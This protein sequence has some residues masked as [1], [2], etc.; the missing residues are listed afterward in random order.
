MHWLV[1]I[2]STPL[3]KVLSD[4]SVSDVGKISVC[5]K[6]PGWWKGSS[7]MESEFSRESARGKT[8][9]SVMHEVIQSL[10][11]NIVK[12][13]FVQVPCPNG[14]F[15]FSMTLIISEVISTFNFHGSATPSLRGGDGDELYGPV[16]CVTKKAC[17]RDL[18]CLFLQEKAP[19][20]LPVTC[21]A[22][23]AATFVNDF[24]MVYQGKESVSNDTPSP[25]LEAC[26][27]TTTTT[28][29]FVTNN[30]RYR[31]NEDEEP[32]QET[33]SLETTTQQ[34]VIH[35]EHRHLMKGKNNHLVVK[36]S[37]WNLEEAHSSNAAVFLKSDFNEIYN[38][39]DSL[40]DELKNNRFY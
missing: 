37:N 26:G 6:S 12:G 34:R 32:L 5:Q 18:A 1:V 19:F 16:T 8:C 25:L 24:S 22:W 33:K 30:N 11:P 20:L 23:L 9:V 38:A 35:H 39:L 28:S 27:A 14:G 2:Y 21:D 7:L 29:S 15:G 31:D 10:G 4:G 40:E 36:E 3:L 13:T 17:K